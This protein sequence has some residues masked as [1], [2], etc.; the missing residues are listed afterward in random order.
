MLRLPDL[1][2]GAPDSELL[3]GGFCRIVAAR[4][5]G[6]DEEAAKLQLELAELIA[7]HEQHDPG[8]A[9]ASG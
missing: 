2:T 8:S 1:D 4:D 6:L 7:Q 5:E 3:V 9:P